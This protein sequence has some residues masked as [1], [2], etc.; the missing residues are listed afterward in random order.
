VAHTLCLALADAL[1]ITANLTQRPPLPPVQPAQEADAQTIAATG[2]Q[3]QL[4]PSG[5]PPSRPH[6]LI[7][8]RVSKLSRKYQQLRSSSAIKPLTS[9]HLPTVASA[10]V[11][12]SNTETELQIEASK[13]GYE[14]LRLQAMTDSYQLKVV[15]QAQLLPLSDV[16]LVAKNKD[17]RK[18]QPKGRHNK[19][20]SLSLSLSLSLYLSLS[21]SL[22]ISLSISISYPHS[23]TF[24]L[25]NRSVTPFTTTSKTHSS[26]INIISTG[27]TK[28]G[29]LNKR[30]VYHPFL[31]FLL[32][33][34][35]TL[36]F[37]FFLLVSAFFF[38][39][40]IDSSSL[41]NPD[42]DDDFIIKTPRS[43]KRTKSVLPLFF[44]CSFSHQL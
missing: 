15:Q 16:N 31:L 41:W 27:N 9:T 8:K 18:D 37:V 21:L 25:I 24:Y 35:P 30:H 44:V 43:K 6:P 22:S 29:Y 3:S 14:R 12:P 23:N 17:V 4:P 28:R 42:N 2:V 7:E 11:T 13:Y 34:L 32:D 33:F 39:D 1:S 20:K 19:S 5:P 36:N 10:K 26:S 40:T 38:S